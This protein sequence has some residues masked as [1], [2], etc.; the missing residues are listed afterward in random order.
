MLTMST[1]VN[2]DLVDINT[3][4]YNFKLY[5]K[6]T[7]YNPAKLQETNRYRLSIL[8]TVPATWRLTLV[9]RRTLAHSSILC[10]PPL[11]L[12]V[13]GRANVEQPH[14]TSNDSVGDDDVPRWRVEA[15]FLRQLQTES[16]VDNTESDDETADPEMR[17]GPE[18]S[19]LVLLV[20]EVVNE[21]QE[22][23]EDE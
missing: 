1:I 13:D 8:N 14:D 6:P 21:T 7:Q 9:W 15:D 4:I 2:F 10:L 20:R 12:T 11:V 16:T 19:S 23:L 17:V 3:I 22:W 5:P 18:D